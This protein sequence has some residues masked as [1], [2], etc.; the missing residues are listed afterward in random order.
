[1]VMGQSLCVDQFCVLVFLYVPFLFVWKSVCERVAGG[2]CS[3][4]VSVR[5]QVTLA[6]SNR[7]VMVPVIIVMKCCENAV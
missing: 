5:I 3:D 6:S 1:M 4:Q 7:M 2:L